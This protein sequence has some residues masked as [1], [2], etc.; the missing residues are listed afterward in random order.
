VNDSVPAY[1]DALVME[2]AGVAAGPLESVYVGGGTPTV[3]SPGQ[4][5]ELFEMLR[6]SCSFSPDAEVT[7]EANPCSLDH[8]TAETL[9]ACGV[10][11]VSVGAQSFS[12]PELSFLRR[13]HGPDDISQSVSLLRE[14]GIDNLSIDLMYALPNQTPES[15]RESLARAIELQ[16]EHISTYCLT[17]EPATPLCVALE[18]GEIEK[19]SGDEEIELYEIA[20]TMLAGSGYEHYEISNFAMP[21]MRSRH[22]MVYWSNDEYLGLGAGAVSYID[23]KR[24]ANLRE[25]AHYIEAMRTDGT[26]AC[27]V[28][29]IPPRMQ[30][31]ETMI[32]RLRLR[33][34]IDCAAFENR[35]GLHPEK[36]FN[37]T[38]G[39]LIDLRLIEKDSRT[40][41]P[42]TKGFHLANE[43]AL[44]VL[45]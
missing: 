23:G 9:A 24:I 10:N 27:E 4:I 7:I 38:L 14:V 39:E 6:E 21:G 33:D 32:Q 2:A 25:P 15:W 31:I 13:A 45:A 34:G 40:I 20:R 8:E 28:E 35:F 44:R 36:L 29:Q 17:F 43:I 16:P 3:L 26:A 41:R 18:N 12:A 30:A 11:R 22:N 42:T 37:G 1:L 19:K 5:A